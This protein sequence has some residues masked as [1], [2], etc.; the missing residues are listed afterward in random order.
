MYVSASGGVDVEVL[1]VDDRVLH[2]RNSESSTTAMTFLSVL[3]L[4]VHVKLPQCPADLDIEDT[5][6]K[7][8]PSIV[9]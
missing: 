6:S 4:N 3:I 8:P 5:G 2:R 1:G 7:R 9:N